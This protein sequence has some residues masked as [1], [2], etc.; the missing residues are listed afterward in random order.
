MKLIKGK[1]VK[2]VRVD[3][4]KMVKFDGVKGRRLSIEPGKGSNGKNG[5]V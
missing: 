4:L 2:M 5:K 1:M 3:G